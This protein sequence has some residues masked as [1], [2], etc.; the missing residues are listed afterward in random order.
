MEQRPLEHHECDWN[1]EY[2]SCVANKLTNK[3]CTILWH[4]DD[5]KISHVDPQVVDSL[6]ENLR[7]TVGK[8]APLTESHGKLD[9]YLGM[10]LSFTLKDRSASLSSPFTQTY[11]D[12]RSKIGNSFQH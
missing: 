6:L 8:E 3:Q 9:D 1:F 5:M 7:N 12:N 10:K 2:D 11:L 4:V